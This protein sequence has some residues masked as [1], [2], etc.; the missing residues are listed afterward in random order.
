MLRLTHDQADLVEQILL[1]RHAAG[2]AATLREAWPAVTERLR[3]RWGAFVE[4]ALQ[5]GHRLGLADPGELAR[6]ASLWCVWGAAF[7]EKPEFE[8]AREIAADARRPPALKLHQL[9][10][11]T[12]EELARQQPRGPSAVAM[13]GVAQF[14]A[15]LAKVGAGLADQARAQAVFLDVE[16]PPAIRACDLATID[17][18]VAEAENLLEYRP[19]NGQWQRSPAP[20]LEAAPL[21]WN[22]APDEPLSLSVP[23]RALRGGPAARLNLRLQPLAV[24][25]PRVHPEVQHR[26]EQGLLAWRGRDTA[27][28][29]LPLYARPAPPQDAAAG[30][31]GIAA[32]LEAEAQQVLIDT[33]GARDAG[34][35]FG[36]VAI[37][38]KVYPATQWLAEWRHE[39]WPAQAW[40][41]PAPPP[42]PSARCTLAADGQPRDAAAWQR[43]WATLQAQCRAGLEKLF[44]AWARQVDGP[45]ARLEA[46]VAPLV[47]QAALT[48]GPR[49]IE[50]DRVVM[51]SAGRIDLTALAVDLRLA[52]DLVLGDARARVVLSCQGQCD[53]RMAV[54]QLGELA[55]E[56]QGLAE[57]K[58][59]WRFPLALE[60]EPL[61]TGALSMLNAIAG[62]EGSLG[63]LVGECGLRP[64]PDGRGLQWHFALRAEPCMLTL[65]SVDPLLGTARVQRTLLPALPLV[66]WSAG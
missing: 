27:R 37:G 46:Q 18:M 60:L 33:C 10:H 14:D 24:C 43:G 48:W 44:N 23:S 38:L 55:P 4:A 2:V 9:I 53:L 22:A 7:D 63:A 47:G 17:L 58:R 34:A 36:A 64:R 66:D 20:R 25:D 50:P 32:P 28:L 15:A 11:R 6:Y 3:E 57:V 21:Q 35:P 41:N 31:P 45:S 29:S 65:A 39:A 8:W 61:A 42:A 13:V 12:R 5:H 30:P 19:E 16:P 49:R 40:P 52:G 56:G 62:P 51:R 1:R 59:A 54:E 26:S